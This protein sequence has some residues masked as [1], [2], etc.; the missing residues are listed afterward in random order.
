MSKQ[1]KKLQDN[2]DML[3]YK[4]YLDPQDIRT[5][6]HTLEQFKRE[7]SDTQTLEIVNELETKLENLSPPRNEQEISEIQSLLSKLKES[8]R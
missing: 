1:F 4:Y 6:K 3:S 8:R 5:T 2:I 7:T